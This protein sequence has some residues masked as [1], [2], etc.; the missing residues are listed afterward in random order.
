MRLTDLTDPPLA[1][2]ML[3][4]RLPVRVE[5][6]MDPAA[7]PRAFAWFPA[8]GAL[9]GAAGGLALWAAGSALPP[10]AAA[11]VAVAVQVRLTGGLHEDGLADLADGLGGGRDRARTLAIM[12]D[13]RIGTYG[14]RAL[15]LGIGLR[16][17]LLAPL[18]GTVEAVA[19]LAAAGALS[20]APLGTMAATMPPARPDG[21]A[22]A[23]GRP[24]A[25]TA[26]AAAMLGLG[27]AAALVPQW[28]VMAAGAALAAAAVAASALRRLG[29]VTGDVHGGAQQ[30]AEI[31]ALLALSAALSGA[32]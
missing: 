3:L 31:A 30:A 10:L 15:V 8:V 20:R 4:T 16:A 5:R 23:Q 27:L 17:A 2:L 11:L 24:S 26:A 21:L 9:V 19:V 7:F 6:P 25:A 32:I 14:V 12:R 28:P 13:S 22:V 1:A 18:A 29:G